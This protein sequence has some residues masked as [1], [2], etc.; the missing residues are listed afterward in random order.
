MATVVAT[1]M[2]R[3][4]R[5]PRRWATARA[6]ATASAV[7][8]SRTGTITVSVG[9]TRVSRIWETGSWVDQLS[10]KSKVAAWRAKRSSCR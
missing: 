4:V 3:S 7:S 9:P 2:A 8:R 6:S 10:P 1:M 5:V